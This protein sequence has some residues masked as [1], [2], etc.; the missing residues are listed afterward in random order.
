[1]AIFEDIRRRSGLVIV[2]IG[3]SLLAFVLTDL[4][5]SGGVLFV[6]DSVGTINGKE[7]KIQEFNAEMEQNLKHS[8]EQNLKEFRAE[9]MQRRKT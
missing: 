8:R 5:S 1:M 4:L 2:L 9:Y 3:L 7:V 6:D